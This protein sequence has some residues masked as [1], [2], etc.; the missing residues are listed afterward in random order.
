[1][2]NRLAIDLFH[3]KK[4]NRNNFVGFY[5]AEACTSAESPSALPMTAPQWVMRL[6]SCLWKYPPHTGQRYDRW[7][8]RRFLLS[9]TNTSAKGHFVTAELTGVDRFGAACHI[10]KF[11]NPA[12]DE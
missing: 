10:F 12:F 7:L 11:G 8:L 5:P 3:I 9:K 6:K 1:M 4:I 2:S